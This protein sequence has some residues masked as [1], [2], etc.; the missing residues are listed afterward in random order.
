MTA[1]SKALEAS[2]PSLSIGLALPPGRLYLVLWSLPVGFVIV[3]A[4]I[5]V[6]P[7]DEGSKVA[8]LTIFGA[9][10]LA[11]LWYVL[12]YRSPRTLVV[13][14]FGFTFSRSSKP[15]IV[16]RW[17]DVQVVQYGRIPFTR[18]TRIVYNPYLAVYGAKTRPIR[19]V[20]GYYGVPSGTLAGI[21]QAIANGA[22]ARGIPVIQ[23]DTVRF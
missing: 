5:A 14:D 12:Y 20:E 9:M 3:E 17:Q 10:G 11:S 1:S 21:S 4:L 19:I 23:K 8:A 7:S 2:Q 6:T 18:G 13:D 22:R 16:V 15:R